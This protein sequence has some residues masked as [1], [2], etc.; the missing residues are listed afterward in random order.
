[1]EIKPNE[2]QQKA[3]NHIDGPVML[4]AGPGTGKTYTII[5]RIKNLLSKGVE[6]ERI[7]ALTFSQPAANEMKN[8]LDKELNILDSGVYVSTYHSFCLDVI[9]NHPQ[10][11]DLP[12]NYKIMTDT[13]IKKFIKECIDKL[14]P[15]SYRTKM[16]DPYRAMKEIQ[17]QIEE[18]KSYRLT[19]EQY[20]KN[21]KENQD[22]EPELKRATDK[23]RELQETGKK[24]TDQAIK[25]VENAQKR[26][27]KAN[28]LW[29]LYELYQSKMDSEH[30]IDFDDMIN[31]VLEKFDDNPSFL[32]EVANQYD[33]LF[34][35][36]YQDTNKPQNDIIIKITE[37]M[38][39]RN[40][41]VVGDDDQIIFTFQGAKPDTM[42]K[43]LER[44]PETEKIFL[45]EN[46]RSTQSILDFAELIAK[47]DPNRLKSQLGI[48]G[49]LTAKNEKIIKFDKP[50]ELCKYNNKLEEYVRIVDKIEEIINSDKCPKNDDGEKDLS[51][52]AI[53]T[54]SN[55]EL[56]SFA[57][58]LKDR[59]ISYELKDG[60]NIFLIKSSLVL[61]YYMQMLT[62]P[63]LHSD[64]I[65]KLLLLPPF[66]INSKDYET[67]FMEKTKYP[68][69]IDAMRAID[70]SKFKEPEK[71]VDFVLT[72]DY[73][74]SYR[75][76]E[77]LKNVVLEIGAKTGI[78]D[79]F[80]NS[81]INKNE[82]IAGI[83]KIIDEAKN[84]SDTNESIILDYFVEYLEMAYGGETVIKTDKAPVT[85]NA[86]Q[87]STY[88]SSKGREFSYVFMPTLENKKWES[89]NKSYKAIIPLP[90]SEYKNK[91]ELAQ[92]KWADNVKLMYVGMT[93]ARHSLYLSYPDM[94]DSKTQKLTKLISSHQD[95]TSEVK[96]EKLDEDKYWAQI[97]KTFIKRDYDYTKEFHA[98]VDA[99]LAQQKYSP[100]SVNTYLKCP[101]Q[102]FYEYILDFPAKDGNADNMHYGSAVHE[103][104][105]KAVKFALKNEYY[106]QKSEFIKFFTDKLNNLPISTPEMRKI[107]SERGENALNTYYV[108]L[109]NTPVNQLHAAEKRFELPL[110]DVKFC[111]IIDRID[112][113]SDGTYSIYD[114]KTGKAKDL[115]IICIGGEHEDY[116]N[117]IALY[118]YFFEKE[119]NCKV[120][121]TGFIFP[122]EC[123]KNL[124]IHFTDEECTAVLEKFRNAIKD[125]RS[126]KFEPIEQK[127]RKKN[128][129]CQYCQYK[130]FCDNEIV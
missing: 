124:D 23:L 31:L 88:H 103:A 2:Q 62:S 77:T 100:T 40:V 6:P 99:K 46:M 86:V 19:K 120:K 35:D 81:E 72:Y 34:V 37:N 73:L 83:A 45:N 25:N 68:T 90:Q 63:E 22:W 7:L 104:C 113:N 126:Y 59:N 69:F 64:K 122:D 117:Q 15:K 13:V 75:T 129:A 118:K 84:Y 108:Q 92:I 93:R 61:F 20:F 10:D 101:R 112:K 125:I 14:E 55:G 39:S 3:I 102:Y 110:D 80:V 79:Y 49:K 66:S 9:K 21:L 107:L 51:E 65:F 26:I 67:L 76:N 82:N 36:E 11:F 27:D 16:N 111:G 116:Y 109:C 12:D 1:M 127:D 121:N 91:E 8:R 28:E 96:P 97:T 42:Q 123:D 53:L 98:I 95:K 60:K 94:T 74:Q 70:K 115:G 32:K 18:I 38:N 130:A 105:E 52:I 56:E 30:Y 41:F 44:F 47:E 71:I 119:S 17:D 128:P 5:E 48:D 78:F 114:Y 33:Y 85:L 57:E 50:V 58:M 54:T 43:F 4:L 29:Q 106:P 87:L 24:I 89:S